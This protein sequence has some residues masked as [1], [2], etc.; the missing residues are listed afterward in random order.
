MLGRVGDD[1]F[2]VRLAF[3]GRPGGADDGNIAFGGD[4]QDANGLSGGFGFGRRAQREGHLAA[5]GSRGRRRGSDPGRQMIDHDH[6]RTRIPVLPGNRDR[7]RR[8]GSGRERVRVI[9]DGRA[10]GGRLRIDVGHL[11]A[12]DVLGPS[13]A[14]EIPDGRDIGPIGRRRPGEPGVVAGPA[15]VVR[16]QPLARCILN[17]QD[18]VERKTE[19]RGKNGKPIRHAFGERHRE[20]IFIAGRINSTVHRARQRHRKGDVGRVVGLDLAGFGQ[21]ADLNM[22]AV[23]RA[24]S[25]HGD[26]A[27]VGRQVSRVHRPNHGSTGGAE[28][29]AEQME[30]RGTPALQA[31]G[32]GVVHV[33]AGRDR[34]SIHGRRIGDETDIGAGRFDE[35]EDAN[36]VRARVLGLPGEQGIE[37]VGVV[38]QGQND[39][40][41]IQH[42]ERCVDRRAE[43]KRPD[44]A[45]QPLARIELD[46]E[47]VE[48][49]AAGLEATVDDDG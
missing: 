3:D 5:L 7:H 43:T 32:E 6:D 9:L 8:R 17:G 44:L 2:G 23:G 33:G 15:V 18:R 30:R 12:V 29:P 46:L 36:D 37:R 16:G 14:Q 11:E 49:A 24:G 19:R 22:Y 42:L 27:D 47:R 41:R 21:D 26:L 34:Q 20:A 45:H 4:G 48:V 40:L 1:G 28:I 35:T 38:V 39:A 10:K 13:R 25:G 31:G